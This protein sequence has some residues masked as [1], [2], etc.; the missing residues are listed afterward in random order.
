[1][2]W[3]QGF[4]HSTGFGRWV[5]SSYVLIGTA[6]SG[7]C[8]L[9]H[10]LCAAQQKRSYTEG[11]CPVMRF[12][13]LSFQWRSYGSSYSLRAFFQSCVHSPDTS[14]CYAHLIAVVSG[15]G[16]SSRDYQLPA[17]LRDAIQNVDGLSCSTFLYRAHT[18]TSRG[19]NPIYVRIFFDCA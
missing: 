10:W 2:F 17:H 19:L 9:V 8:N 3:Y 13:S 14:T 15:S 6:L 4:L 5:P 7:D 1:M 18:A 16:G 12:L 11:L